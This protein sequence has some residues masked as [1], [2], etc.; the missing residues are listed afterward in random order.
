MEKQLQTI[1][2]ANENPISLHQLVSNMLKSSLSAAN[3]KNTHLVN[4]VDL[5]IP[6]GTAMHKAIAVIEDLLATVVANSR[7]GEIHITADRYRDVVILEIQERNNYNGYALAYSILSM[8][9][10]AASAGGYLS[11]KGPQQK[12]TTI[13][14]S[15][16][17]NLLAA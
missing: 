1:T 7:N 5:L 10:D 2:G 14:F 4:E 12:V 9:Q 15:F 11:I 13:S 6:M 16:P 8:E 3:H 17:S